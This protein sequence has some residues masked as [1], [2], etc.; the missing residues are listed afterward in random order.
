MKNNI[1][2]KKA[3]KEDYNKVVN[4]INKVFRINRG[5]K[6]TMVNE[7]PLL[8]NKDN[9]SQMIIAKDN[10]TVVS[11]V[12]FIKNKLSIEGSI[13]TQSSI[14]GV[15]TDEK[16]RGRKISSNILKQVEKD[17]KAKKISVCTISGNRSLYTRWG[18]CEV[19]SFYKYYLSALDSNEKIEFKEINEDDINF[20]IK[21]YSKEAIRFLRK[22]DEFKKLLKSATIPW[23]DFTYIS[24]MV[25]FNNEVIGY[26]ILRKIENSLNGEIVE[27]NCR[28]DLLS[29]VIRKLAFLEGLNAIEHYVG[30]SDF[31]NQL[32]NYDKKEIV[33]Q[34]GTVKIIDYNNLMNE[35]DLYFTQYLEEDEISG[36]SYGY[37]GNYYFKYNDE[38]LEIESL[39]KLTK[40]VFCFSELNNNLYDENS[41]LIKT[42]KKIFPVQLP[43]TKNL[44]YQ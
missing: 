27:I 31:K 4:L 35:L 25:L 21:R 19:D 20:M 11:T 32:Y 28:E 17:M 37:N 12:N 10:D 7:F 40:I 29:N 3:S 15:C 39:E 26:V 23:G 44:N 38:I 22:K 2:I 24:K 6:P 14:G 43:Y 1:K 16:Y 36:F 5:H 8:L 34:H 18:A 13:I 42:L 33:P 30:I 9:H 41:S